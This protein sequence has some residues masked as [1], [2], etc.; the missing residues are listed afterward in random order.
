MTGLCTVFS[1]ETIIIFL[2]GMQLEHNLNCLFFVQVTSCN[3]SIGTVN[4]LLRS[5]LVK[6]YIFVYRMQEVVA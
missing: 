6:S 5:K 1:C 4:N 3:N 2:V